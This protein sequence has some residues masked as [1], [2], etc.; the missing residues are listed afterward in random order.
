MY[1]MIRALLGA[2]EK[3]QHGFF[4]GQRSAAKQR[5]AKFRMFK[6]PTPTVGPVTGP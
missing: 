3:A 1:A 2:T 6:T 5:A 4:N